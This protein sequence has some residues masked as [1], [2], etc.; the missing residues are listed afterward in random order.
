MPRLIT[1]LCLTALFAF[2]QICHAAFPD[3]DLTGVIMW[4]AG[5]TTDVTAKAIVPHVEQQL[6]QRISLIN[7]PG[8]S[9][10]IATE[11]VRH[12]PA[13][14][15]TLLFGAENPQLHKILGLADF[16][17]D[18][19][20]PIAIY[21]RGIGV[22]VVKANARW[23]NMSDLVKE[24]RE[25]PESIR[26]AVTGVGG[27]PHTVG[28][29]ITAVTN[30]QLPTLQFDG[31]GSVI[32]SVVSGQTEFSAVGLSAAIE[33]IKAGRIR[34]IAVVHNEPISTLPAV[35]PITK[36]LPEFAKFLPW[37]PFYGVFVKKDTPVAIKEKLTTA[38]AIASRHPRFRQIMIERGNVPMYLTG[39]DADQFL[40][41]WQS[42]TSWLLYN[43]G[44][45]KHS[46]AKFNIPVPQGGEKQP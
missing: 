41:Q 23:Q 28:A 29:M 25:N 43:V 9:G 35:P 42:T 44:A 45:A 4:G 19:F 16:D 14:G 37:A 7:K 46:P 36:D 38:F 6:N 17:Y 15:Y 40:R 13:D 33:S 1:A 27:L 24:A 30:L 32:A 31:E 39:S 12:L 22:V 18:Q 26:M 10:A 11:Y 34:A 3:R 2:T 21:G 20:T 5:G 8:F